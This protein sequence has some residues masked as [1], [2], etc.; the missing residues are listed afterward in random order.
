MYNINFVKIEAI[1]Y[2]MAMVNTTHKN[3]VEFKF[4]SQ[5]LNSS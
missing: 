5:S 2:I 1:G 3:Y 4:E